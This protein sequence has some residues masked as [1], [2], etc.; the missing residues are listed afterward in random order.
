MTVSEANGKIT[1]W[2][3]TVHMSYQSIHLIGN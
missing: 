1:R 2:K 3:W